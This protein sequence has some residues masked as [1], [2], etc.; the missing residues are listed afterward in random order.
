MLHGVTTHKTNIDIFTI[1]WTLILAQINDS[2]E[3]F[4][5][6][7]TRSSVRNGNRHLQCKVLNLQLVVAGPCGWMWRA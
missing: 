3:L 2:P 6:W 7:R 1:V 5:R 4:I